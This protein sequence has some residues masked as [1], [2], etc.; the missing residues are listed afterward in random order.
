MKRVR[1][2]KY[3]GDLASEME[4]DDLLKALSDYLLDSGYRDPFTRFSELDHTMNDLKEAL[5]QALEAG[6]L[7]DES[8]QQQ[9][10]E[11]SEL[12]RS[13]PVRRSGGR[14]PV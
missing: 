2:T 13:R 14:G 5:R 4:M 9:I 11:M 10:D 6:D 12:T 8:M 7:F 3:T 1:Y